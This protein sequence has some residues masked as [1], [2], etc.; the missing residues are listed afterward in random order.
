MRAGQ[1]YAII[2]AR[3]GSKGLPMKNIRPLAGKPLIAYS[4]IAALECK[5]I[6]RCFVST[7]APEIKDISM[8]WGAEVI[9]R[10]LEL[11]GDLTTSNDVVRHV[12]E[13]LSGRD[14]FPEYFVLLQ[15]TSPLRNTAHIQDCLEAFFTSDAVCAISVTEPKPHPYKTFRVNDGKL[16][17]LFGIEYLHQPRQM[18]PK[19]FRQNGAIYLAES[20]IFLKNNSFFVPPALPFLMNQEDS[21]DIDTEFDFFIA[22]SLILKRRKIVGQNRL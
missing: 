14:D 16:E 6:D 7:E 12:L 11:S 3:G 4:I 17:P 8:Q 20:E 15:P 19:V 18:L 21:I 5:G 13:T 22:E 1:V 10:P 9:D 2:T